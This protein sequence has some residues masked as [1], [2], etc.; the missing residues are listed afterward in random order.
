MIFTHFEAII[1]LL[2]AVF[3]MLTGVAVSLRWVYRQGAANESLKDSVDRLSNATNDLSS[4]YKAFTLKIADS[5]LDHEKRLTRL[6]TTT[7]LQRR[8]GQ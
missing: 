4:S 5:L 1:A 7:E 8:N 6:E 2:A 3:T